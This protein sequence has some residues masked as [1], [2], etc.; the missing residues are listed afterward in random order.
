[1]N[2]FKSLIDRDIGFVCL[3]ATKQRVVCLVLLLD[4]MV[5]QIR[6]VA[7]KSPVLHYYEGDQHYRL[8]LDDGMIT[9]E[10][11]R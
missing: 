11:T 8:G 10:G 7:K 3:L 9:V 1:M 2:W 5:E 6:A 4:E